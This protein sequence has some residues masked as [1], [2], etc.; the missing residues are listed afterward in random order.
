MASTAAPGTIAEPLATVAH[1]VGRASTGDSILLERGGT[2]FASDLNAGSDLS[3]TAYGNGPRPIVTG[4]VRVS[5][6]GTWGANPS[7]RTGSVAQRVV[8]CYVN[9]RFVRLARWPNVDDGL[10]PQRQRQRVRPHRRCRARHPTRSG[11]RPLDRRPGPLAASGAGGG[12]PGPSPSTAP[13]TLSSSIR[14]GNVGDQPRRSR[15]GLLHR[16]RSR[17]ARCPRR[18]ALGGGR[19]LSLSPVLGRSRQP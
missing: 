12:R 7:V 16:Q 6:S 11:A 13:S 1:A 10:S 8:A 5:L 14:P 17:R 3:V 2:Y 18:V 9:G 4:S 19:A 15:L